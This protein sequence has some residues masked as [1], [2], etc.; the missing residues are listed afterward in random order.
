MSRVG[1]L[2]VS[3]MMKEQLL[4]SATLVR[5]PKGTVLFQ[6]GDPGIGVYLIRRGTVSL[7]LDVANPAFPPRLCGPGAVVGLPAAV[8]GGR[9]SLTA[10]VLKD[11]E[12]AF[13]SRDGLMRCL[14]QS[15]QLCLEV[16]QL[17]SGEIAGTR[18]ALK[19]RARPLSR[20]A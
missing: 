9:Y 16:M 20:G 17:L 13:V 2:T 6:H 19:E 14:A 10:E 15:P 18:A 3:K 11:A 5:K 7:A 1:D 8:A 4:R 12:L